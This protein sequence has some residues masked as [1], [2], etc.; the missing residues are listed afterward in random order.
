MYESKSERLAAALMSG[1]AGAVTKERLDM[2]FTR[3]EKNDKVAY[4][5]MAMQ[6]SSEELTAAW[7]AYVPTMIRYRQPTLQKLY[8]LMKAR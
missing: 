2:M 1:E 8:R 5:F 3:R 6:F 4:V 7:Q